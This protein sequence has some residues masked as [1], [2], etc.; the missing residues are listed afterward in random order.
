MTKHWQLREIAE[1][2]HP[3]IVSE[4]GTL[5][6]APDTHTNWAPEVYHSDTNDVDIMGEGWE[7]LTGYTGQYAYNGAVMHQSEYIGGGLADDIL[8]TPG[9]Y[10]VVVV[11]VLT[12]DEDEEPAGWAVLRHV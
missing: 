12:L 8:N 3:F 7:A 4:D 6:D 5:S 11:N 2:D 9:T 10:V 1:F